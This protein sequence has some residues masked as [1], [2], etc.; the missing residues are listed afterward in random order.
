LGLIVW[1]RAVLHLI[2]SPHCTPVLR[3]SLLYFFDH[4]FEASCVSISFERDLLRTGPHTSLSVTGSSFESMKIPAGRH[5]ERKRPVIVTVTFTLASPHSW[6]P[7]RAQRM[8]SLSRLDRW[9]SNLL[10]VTSTFQHSPLVCLSDLFQDQQAHDLVLRIFSFYAVD[11]RGTRA[12][13]VD[14]RQRPRV[15]PRESNIYLY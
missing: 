13:I 2:L 11:Q 4:N 12:C 6:Y 7:T 10:L 15:F 9:Q 5:P 3:L 1:S 14:D 8:L